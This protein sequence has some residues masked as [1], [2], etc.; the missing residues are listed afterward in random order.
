[1]PVPAERKL[2]TLIG[3]LASND[4]LEKNE[5]LA[6]VFREA[7]KNE[8]LRETLT[9]FRF[10]FTGG[11]YNRL[12]RGDRVDV[13][14]VPLE[15]KYHLDDDIKKFLHNE[16]GIIRLPSNKEG[17]VVILSCLVAQRKVSILW[18]FFSPITTH[19]LYPDN[20]ALL[21]LAD[22]WHAKKLMN[23]GSVN[24]WIRGEMSKD[25][26]FNRQSLPLE[27]EFLGETGK[28]KLNEVDLNDPNKSC[29]EYE[30]QE[31]PDFLSA[32]EGGELDKEL[33]KTVLVL[34]SH[35]AMK[36]RMLDFVIDYEHELGKFKKILTT[37]TTGRLIQDTVPSLSGIV[38]RHHSG[39]KGGDIEIAT[40]ILLGG[41]H[42]V[43]FF[44]DPLHPHP[45]TE[46][47]RVVFAACM[48]QNQVRILSN[49][50]QARDWIDRMIRN[51]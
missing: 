7:Y 4:S 10:V 48:I 37:G 40:E 21:R 50:M 29:L 38:K 26:N 41:C 12:I 46:D 6:D 31:F 3:V 16:C 36:D 15:I 13:I 47:I 43:V 27:L 30:K 25:T 24:E 33:E 11:T 28:M 17:G 39:P 8:S 44:V 22:L 49:E 51:R 19:L 1:M 14:N 2:K 20:I 32:K 34:I 35:D 23:S 42:V 5:A 9:N 18:P 45:H